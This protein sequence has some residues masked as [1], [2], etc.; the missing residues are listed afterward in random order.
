MSQ[1][2]SLLTLSVKATAAIAAHTFVTV[3]GAT[4]AAGADAH[5]VALCDA[6]SGDLFGADVLGTTIVKVDADITAGARLAVGASGG[7]KPAVASSY[8]VARA[9]TAA[10]AGDLTEV[11]LFQGGPTIPA[12]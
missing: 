7:V 11:L 6:A 3:A 12:A 2:T 5:G 9:L 8:V 4:A 1:K 10:S